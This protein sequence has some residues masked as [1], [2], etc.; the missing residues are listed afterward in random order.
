MDK[1][2]AC[3]ASDASSPVSWRSTSASTAKMAI[4]STSRPLSMPSRELQQSCHRM[5]A[6]RLSKQHMSA[7]R[8]EKTPFPQ[9]HGPLQGSISACDQNVSCADQRAMISTEFSASLKAFASREG[10][11]EG[12]GMRKGQL[13]G[14]KEACESCCPS[15]QAPP[16]AIPANKCLRAFEHLFLLVCTCDS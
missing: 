9:I 3:S 5:S 15:Y 14:C 16:N 13:P 12:V 4:S 6:S 10:I 1:L 2:P 11:L 7:S 8:S